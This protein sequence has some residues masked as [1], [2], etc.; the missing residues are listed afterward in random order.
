MATPHNDIAFAILHND[1]N[2]TMI[3]VKTHARAVT[4]HNHNKNQRTGTVKTRD[5]MGHLD[6]WKIAPGI[7][8]SNKKLYIKSFD[9]F[10]GTLQTD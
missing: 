10:H 6:V 7:A 4:S 9:S 8:A 3:K 5:A 2:I 1:I